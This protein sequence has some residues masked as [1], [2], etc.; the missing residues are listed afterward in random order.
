M[1]IASLTLSAGTIVAFVN[2]AG[3]VRSDVLPLVTDANARPVDIL[4]AGNGRICR[5]EVAELDREHGRAE[6]DIVRP[7]RR[8]IGHREIDVTLLDGVDDV[9][10]TR[11]RD[12]S[13]GTFSRLA[14]SCPRSCARPWL[15]SV[16][17]S[18][19]IEVGLPG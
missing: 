5:N 10:D 3:S 14:N 6:G 18:T 7:R 19:T 8:G 15:S 17:G 11:K 13:R 9:G 2:L 12:V 1:P 4:G 16:T